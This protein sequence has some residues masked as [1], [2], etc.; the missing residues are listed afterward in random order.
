MGRFKTGNYVTD[1][2]SA[3]DEISEVA[4]TYGVDGGE[5]FDLMK[6]RGFDPVDLLQTRNELAGDIDRSKVE[7]AMWHAIGSL[8]DEAVSDGE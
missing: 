4:N 2:Q 8:I 6:A 5:V 3:R 7:N 1:V